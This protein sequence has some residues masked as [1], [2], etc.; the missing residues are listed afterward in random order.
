MGRCFAHGGRPCRNGGNIGVC[1]GTS[2]PAGT[3]M[4]TALYSASADSVPFLCFTR[5]GSA[6]PCA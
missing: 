1:L 2:G 4:I 5:P 6:L 3:D